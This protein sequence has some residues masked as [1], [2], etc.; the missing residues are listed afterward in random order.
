MA[1]EPPGSAIADAHALTPDE[2]LALARALHGRAPPAALVTVA[3]RDF[4]F[5]QALSAEVRA[6]LPEAQA[7]ARELA[8]SFPDRE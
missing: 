4:S 1:H 6:A 7:R 2:I 3:G 8:L 5:G